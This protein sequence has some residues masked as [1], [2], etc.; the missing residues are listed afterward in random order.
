MKT[1]VEQVSHDCSQMILQHKKTHSGFRHIFKAQT[2]T[3]RHSDQ[4][5]QVHCKLVDGW[6]FY[7]W[8]QDEIVVRNGIV[9]GHEKRWKL[10]NRQSTALW[11]S[12]WRIAYRGVFFCHPACL[13]QCG[14]VFCQC[15]IFSWKGSNHNI[16][17]QIS[18]GL[19]PETM[20]RMSIG[21]KI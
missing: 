4:V 16:F 15:N 12:L 20:T 21:R 8:H 7:D 11:M 17:E 14:Q 10:A 5:L 18:S 1:S 9:W 13:I 6:D 19:V 2:I 3:V